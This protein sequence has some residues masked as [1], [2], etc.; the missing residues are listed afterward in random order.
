MKE[1]NV[2]DFIYLLNSATHSLLP[3]K[4]VEKVHTITLEDKSVHHIIQSTNFKKFKLENQNN[5]WFTSLEEAKS[6]LLETAE[7]LINVTLQ[8]AEEEKNK[9]FGTVTISD[10]N[11][12]VALN[13][14]NLKNQ[15]D[16]QKDEVYVK[17]ENGQKA[18]ININLSKD[19][20][21]ENS[22]Y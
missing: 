5:P 13:K 9:A 6:F 11:N 3:C 7:K 4:I 17:L 14:N 10:Y 12:V 22:D 19:F 20:K 8:K 16:Y 15:D 18:K 2:G 1:L 21:H